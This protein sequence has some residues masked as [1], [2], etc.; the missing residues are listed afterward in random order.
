MKIVLQEATVSKDSIF[1]DVDT[2]KRYVFKNGHFEEYK[3]KPPK[4]NDS[5]SNSKKDSSDNDSDSN[6]NDSSNNTSKDDSNK[7]N[8]DNTDD[9]ESNDSSSKRQSD[10]D[11][12][13]MTDRNKNSSSR[14]SSKKDSSKKDSSESD[15]S[16][17]SKN[18]DDNGSN[19]EESILDKE[20]RE[21]EAN[22]V[23]KETDEERKARIQEIQD[24]LN[25]E[26][27]RE[28]AVREAE[29]KAY[30]SKERYRRAKEKERRAELAKYDTN[31]SLEGFKLSLNKFIRDEI[32]NIQHNTYQ[33]IN[34]TYNIN[35][36]N[37]IRRGSALRREN[38]I[39][40]INVY[41]DQSGSW[42]QRDV[43][44][45]MQAISTLKKYENNG[46]IKI[47]IYYFANRVSSSNIGIGT[48]TSAGAEIMQHIKDTKPNNIIVMTDSD[49]DYYDN[50]TAENAVTVPG[51]VWFLWKNGEKCVSLAKYLRGKKLNKEFNIVIN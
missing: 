42:S 51:A 40:I 27:S 2:G 9:K 41:F 47:F 26:V 14:D 10:D 1:V 33:K 19:G 16:D 49:I 34:K 13:D 38:S 11:S 39:P 18:S 12:S 24:L 20:A 45:G 3:E 4:N 35:T 37:I 36:G 25:D 29:R 8:K 31:A 23:T 7:D 15:N 44:V 6:N 43:E 22:D 5:D 30:D 50:V 46:Q 32:Q 21:R 28:S 17:T 48:G